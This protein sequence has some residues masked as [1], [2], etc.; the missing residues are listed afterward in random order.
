MRHK[1]IQCIAY[2]ATPGA[3]HYQS[4]VSY[5]G[6]VVGFSQPI[7]PAQALRLFKRL[8]CIRRVETPTQIF[9]NSAYLY[10][11]PQSWR[12]YRPSRH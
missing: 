9:L 5:S 4:W 2:Q 12:M 8:P 6:R 11:T 1:P 3:C 10:T 7:T